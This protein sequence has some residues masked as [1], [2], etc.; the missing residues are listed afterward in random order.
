MLVFRNHECRTLVATLIILFGVVNLAEAKVW[1]GIKPLRSTRADVER[2][3]GK[4]RA[5]RIDW[6]AYDFETEEVSIEYSKGPCSVEFSPWNVPLGTVLSVW[7]TPMLDLK[8][9]DL[10][11]NSRNFR[12]TRD[13]HVASIVHYLDEPDG[14]EYEVH[15]TRGVVVL[16]KYLPSA[17][18]KIMRCPEPAN[19]L[20]ETVKLDEFYD[21][22][23]RASKRHLNRFARQLRKYTSINY[24][25]AEGHILAYAGRSG[26]DNA[27]ARADRAKEYLVRVWRIDPR[28][29]ETRNAGRR[30][31]QTIELYLVPAGGDP[32]LSRPSVRP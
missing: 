5:N 27:K 14:I 30:Q 12:R 22:S 3:L 4:P 29:I 8:V 10:D 32:P 11:L 2:V 6:A 1:R 9:S 25:S 19:R 23:L 7:V 26:S 17:A 24:A 15:E 13:S 31:R 28:R 16:I 21:T 18:D 20:R